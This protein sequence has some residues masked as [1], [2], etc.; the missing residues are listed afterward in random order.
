MSARPSR[1]LRVAIAAGLIMAMP[2]GASG[3]SE[4]P[5]SSDD[6]EATRAMVARWMET[7]RI[8]ARERQEWEEARDILGARILVV[9][10]EIADLQG[11]I[12]EA[13]KAASETGKRRQELAEQLGSL[14]A[15]A[16][17]LARKAGA[18]EQRLRALRGTLP[19]PLQ[20]R[21]E[22]LFLRMPEDPAASRVSVG[23]RFQNV[24]GILNEVHKANT[25]INL[26]SEVRSLS[27]GRPSEVKTVYVG[28]GQAYYV[29]GRGEAGV[30]VPTAEGWAWRP[31]A[32]LARPIARVVDILEGKGS[33]EFVVLPVEIH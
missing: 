3:A 22:P 19:E 7:Q 15:T 14:E 12:V 4:A 25:E 2:R 23:E 17:W 27:G 16:S 29:G 24:L 18:L 33:P 30:G 28:L 32:H 20:R 9:E 1:L 5:S 31:A 21:L 11:S 6:V 13:R 10:K 8:L 26:V